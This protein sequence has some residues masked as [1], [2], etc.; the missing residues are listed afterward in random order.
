MPFP[1]AVMALAA[2]MLASAAA[3]Q[4]EETMAEAVLLELF[5]DPPAEEDFFS[6]DLLARVPL[7]ELSASVSAVKLLAS[8]PERVERRGE[9]FILVTPTHEVPAQAELAAD[10][11]IGRLRIEAP[12]PRETAGQ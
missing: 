1:R 6:A 7:A 5:G 2:A 10:G 8:R 4:G 11:T 9:L 3:A 12:I